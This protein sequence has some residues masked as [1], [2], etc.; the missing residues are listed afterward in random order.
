MHLK[1]GGFIMGRVFYKLGY[2][3]F[4][5]FE[6]NIIVSDVLVKIFLLNSRLRSIK[7]SLNNQV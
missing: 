1:G 2:P 5:S 6:L 7:N 4:S 3:F